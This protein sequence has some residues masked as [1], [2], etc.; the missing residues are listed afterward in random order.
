MAGNAAY[1]EEI[2]GAAGAKHERGA[3]SPADNPRRL[4]VEI[5]KDHVVL[6]AFAIQKRD[7]D[8]LALGG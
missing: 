7:L 1:V 3:R 4:G 2:S 5:R 6:G 8:D